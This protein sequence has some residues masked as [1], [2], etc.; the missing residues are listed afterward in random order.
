MTWPKILKSPLTEKEIK[1][2]AEEFFGDM[3]K[4]VADIDRKVIAVGGSLHADSEQ[5]LLKRGSKQ[6]NLWGANYF[7]FRK[8][9]ERV[10]FSALMNI[11]P[12]E[13]NRGQFI[14]SSAIRKRVEEI[15]GAYFEL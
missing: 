13:G 14:Q 5:L 11:R 3:I 7:P 8:K 9:G 15:I 1:E 4:V 12:R 6:S 2:L 10:E